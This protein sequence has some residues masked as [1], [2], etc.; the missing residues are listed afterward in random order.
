MKCC[1][2]TAGMLRHLVNFEAQQ[3][4]ADGGG[5][6]KLNWVPFAANVPGFLNPMVR[7]ARESVFAKRLETNITHHFITRFRADI[8][9]DHR[10]VFNGRLFQI[11][12]VI[13]MEERNIWLDL[14]LEEGPIT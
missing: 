5:G 8:D 1:D 13:N 6:S 2:I 10:V 7:S 4:V 12:G 11:R 14:V 9:S 3:N